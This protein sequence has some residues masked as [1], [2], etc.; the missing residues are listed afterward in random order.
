MQVFADDGARVD[1][2][3]DGSNDAAVVLIAGFPLTREIWDAQ[4]DALSQRYRVVRPNLRGT[5]RSGSA[6]G[7]YLMERL[8]A[9][10]AAALDALGIERAAIAGHS[11]GGYVAM[12]FARMFAE[13]VSHVALVCSRLRADAPEQAAARRELADRV[14]REDSVQ[15]VIDAYVPRLFAPQTLRERPDLVAP[16]ARNR[17]AHSTRRRGC[18]AARHVDAIQCRRRRPRSRRARVRRRRRLRS[19]RVDGRGA[20]HGGRIPA[21]PRRRV[22]GERASSDARR[23]RRVERRAGR[24]AQRMTGRLERRRKKLKTRKAPTAKAATIAATDDDLQRK[25]TISSKTIASVTAAVT[26]RKSA[27]TGFMVNLIEPAFPQ[28]VPV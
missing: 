22:R 15:P 1:V 17:V 28:L 4:S 21:W 26:L 27:R 2:R 24:V 9:D 20:R 13:R 23:A 19:G 18:A 5:V 25:P 16:R 3:V 10:V 12:A 14:E 7:P 8:A 6:D 11:L